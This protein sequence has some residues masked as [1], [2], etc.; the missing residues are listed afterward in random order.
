MILNNEFATAVHEAG[1]AVVGRVMA[2]ECGEVS[3]VADHDE[4]TAGYAITADPWDT[5][6]AWDRAGRW[7]EHRSIVIGRIIALMAGRHAEEELC[8]ACKGGD[9]GD[10]NE[11]SAM[12]DD[13]AWRAKQ[14]MSESSQALLTRLER[15]SRVTVKRHRSAIND[16]AVELMRRQHMTVDQV[17]DFLQP[18]LPSWHW[19][20]RA[21]I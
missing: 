10:Q 15:F 7:R 13:G 20:P 4:M 16:L 1:H 8:G 21:Q 3:V 14:D 17:A 19:P 18:R 6:G 11:I 12:I 2:Q 5:V 9:G